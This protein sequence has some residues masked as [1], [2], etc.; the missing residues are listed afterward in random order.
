MNKYERLFTWTTIGVLI[1]FSIGT[2]NYEKEYS[3]KDK[4]EKIAMLERKSDSLTNV[5]SHHKTRV[6]TFDIKRDEVKQ[7]YSEKIKK[8][9]GLPKKQQEL[10][11]DTL[12]AGRKDSAVVT[13]YQNEQC[14]KELANCDSSSMEKDTIIDAQQQ[15]IAATTEMA[16]IYEKKSAEEKSKRERD[17]NKLRRW[18]NAAKIL[19]VADVILVLTIIAI[20]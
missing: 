9:K 1:L 19:I 20:K 16:S 17:A 11:F 14:Q 6:D 5:I 8:V 13:F 7:Q 2:C 12:Y 10:L 4:D 18:K 15:V 3:D